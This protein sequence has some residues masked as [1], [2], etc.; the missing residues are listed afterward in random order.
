MGMSVGG[1]RYLMRRSPVAM[2]GALLVLAMGA[3][4]VFATASPGWRG[5]YL[6]TAGPG[7]LLLSVAAPSRNDAWAVGEYTQQT[8]P[9][10]LHWNGKRWLWVNVPEAGQG[11]EP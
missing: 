2:A 4:Q 5:V 9:M 11:F 10:I 1:M 6:A 7:N 3:S 8:G